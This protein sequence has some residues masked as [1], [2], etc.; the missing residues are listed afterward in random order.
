LGTNTGEI[1]IVSINNIFS[2]ICRMRSLSTTITS[3]IEVHPILSSS[4][5]KCLIIYSSNQSEK[6]IIAEIGCQTHPT[7]LFRLDSPN[8][9]IKTLSR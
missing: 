4:N 3:L 9:W 7:E 8:G 5:A 2:I 1:L 6:T